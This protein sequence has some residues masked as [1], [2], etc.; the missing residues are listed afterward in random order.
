MPIQVDHI[1][2]VSLK[3]HFMGLDDKAPVNGKI[4][5]NHNT[6]DVTFGRFPPGTRPATT[7]AEYIKTPS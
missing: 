5:V 2:S 7:G 3:D 4:T 1:G 6:F